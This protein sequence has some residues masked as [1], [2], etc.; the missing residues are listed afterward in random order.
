MRQRVEEI[1]ATYKTSLEDAYEKHKKL[2][3]I[4]E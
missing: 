3:T 1:E 4:Y 2:K